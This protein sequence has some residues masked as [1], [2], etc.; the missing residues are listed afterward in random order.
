MMNA[1]CEEGKSAAQRL[2]RSC[3]SSVKKSG[4]VCAVIVKFVRLS[5]ALLNLRGLELRKEGLEECGEG[6]TTMAEGEFGLDVEFGHGLALLGEIEEWVVAE[7]FGAAWCGE[8]LAVDGTVPCGED[9]TVAGCG[10]D[11]AIAGGGV[12]DSHSTES[13]EEAEVVALVDG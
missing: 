2:F 4:L 11:A 8:D 1:L 7:S 5:C 10:K 3:R 6:S 13:F 9:L 12:W